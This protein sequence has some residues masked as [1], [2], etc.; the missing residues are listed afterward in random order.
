MHTALKE[1]DSDGRIHF[2]EKEGKIYLWFLLYPFLTSLLIY[3]SIVARQEYKIKE[4]EGG[5]L[6]SLAP[7]LPET[8]IQYRYIT[9]KLL[10]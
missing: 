7:G 9:Y 6:M 5:P 4:R 3:N 10:I 2:E 8:E 1:L